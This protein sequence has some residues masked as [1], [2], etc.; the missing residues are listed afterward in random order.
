MIYSN[1]PIRYYNR[2]KGK[3]D[4]I[5]RWLQLS[6]ILVW[7]IFMFGLVSLLA[8]KP[9]EEGFFDRLFNVEVR[10]YWDVSL[11]QRSVII[12]IIQFAISAVLVF[13][14]TKRLKRR[15]DRIYIS[16]FISLGLS[17]LMVLAV[18]LILLSQ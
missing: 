7:F 13:L 12:S 6:S 4:P 9:A 11:L 17:L 18:T 16:H 1:E 8:A 10:S 3:P 2:R 14:N 5:I 15:T